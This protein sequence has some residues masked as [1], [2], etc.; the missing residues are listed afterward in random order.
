MRVVLGSRG[1]GESGVVSPPVLLEKRVPGLQRRE[2]PKPHLLHQPVLKRQV[3]PFDPSLGRWRVRA[4]DVDVQLRQRSAELR[5]A[6][7]LLPRRPEHRRLVRVQR[8]RLAVAPEVRVQGLEV[9]ERRLRLREPQL[10][11]FARRVVDEDD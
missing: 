5:H 6:L 8:H 9:R 3:R 7:G 11:Q 10:H 4:Q 2:P 1:H